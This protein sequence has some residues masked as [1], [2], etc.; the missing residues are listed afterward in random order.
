MCP[1]LAKTLRPHPEVS[2]VATPWRQGQHVQGRVLEGDWGW[3]ISPV[4]RHNVSLSLAQLSATI[5]RKE[6]LQAWP[7]LMQLLQHSTHSPHVPER[8][9]LSHG[10]QE[11]GT[12]RL[13]RPHKFFPLVPHSWA[14]GAYAAKCSGDLPA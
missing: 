12:K 10:W 14:D 1:N 9:V 11:G 2:L 5:F 7:Q 13:D 6:G 8:E 3:G 4:H